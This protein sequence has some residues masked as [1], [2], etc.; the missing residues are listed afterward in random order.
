M[1]RWVF[2]VVYVL[3]M[4]ICMLLAVQ[5]S[6]TVLMSVCICDVVLLM[7]IRSSVYAQLLMLS[8]SLSL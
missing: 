3:D 2:P 8:P 1:S 5:N 4:L 7:S 6:C